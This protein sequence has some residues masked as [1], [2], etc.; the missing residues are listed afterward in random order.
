M[1]HEM[2]TCGRCV[3]NPS[4]LYWCLSGGRTFRVNVRQ[5]SMDDLPGHFILPAFDPHQ[6]SWRQRVRFIITPWCGNDSGTLRPALAP[7]SH[8]ERKVRW[9]VTCNL[10]ASALSKSGFYTSHS[11]RE[12]RGNGGKRSV[13]T[14]RVLD[15]RVGMVSGRT[16]G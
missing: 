13:D 5:G 11:G 1:V 3:S 15:T 16:S 9:K 2:G 8:E 14:R 12:G 6:V 4:S 7:K 10:M